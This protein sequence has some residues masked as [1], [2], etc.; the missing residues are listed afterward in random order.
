M[1]IC[2]HPFVLSTAAQQR[3]KEVLALVERDWRAR[4]A[5]GRSSPQP[6]WSDLFAARA[7]AGV[8]ALLLVLARQG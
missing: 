1:T 4:Q 7:M 3:Q 8:L 6:R 2:L 5:A